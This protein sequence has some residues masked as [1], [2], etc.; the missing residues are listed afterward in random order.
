MRSSLVRD[1]MTTKVV[2]VEPSTPFKQIV[3]RLA[4]HRI[5][6]VPVLDADR[7]VLGVVT[8]ADLL[9]KQEHP[10][11][12]ANV[13]PVWSKRRRREREKAAATVAGNLMTAP[14][15]T[16][17]PTATVAEAA[18][19]LHAAGVKRLPVVDETG[20]L[21]GIV[22]R[23]DLLTVFIRPDQAIRSEIMDKV[24]VADFAMAP[25]RFFIHV[26]DGVV[27]LQGRA[28]RR[29]LIPFLV[30]AVHGVEGVVRVEDRL[31]FDLDDGDAGRAMASPWMWFPW[32]ITHHR[33]TA[34]RG[35][36]I[37]RLRS[38]RRRRTWARS[39][40]QLLNA[41]SHCQPWWQR[42]HPYWDFPP[43]IHREIIW[44]CRPALLAIACALGDERQPISATALRQLSRFLTDPTSSPLFGDAPMA[45]R[46]AARLLECS[47]TG[48]PEP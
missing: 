42:P 35:E 34:E 37:G 6:A 41:A 19:R 32:T 16:V 18:R 5:S 30:R 8:E 21:V 33:P 15:I 2:A 17:P 13:P 23:A 48:H 9:L 46:R 11:P 1:V 36:R 12:E 43:L 28:E 7:R 38:M 14:A 25:S 40:R 29:N 27:V 22:S 45:A 24:I 31:T 3:A 4:R 10:G 44:A 39:V 47:F 20:R 26:D